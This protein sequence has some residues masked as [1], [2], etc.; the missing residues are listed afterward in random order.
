MADRRHSF[1]A[2]L[3]NRVKKRAMSCSSP[4]NLVWASHW[5]LWYHQHLYI[6]VWRFRV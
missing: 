2:F 4:R 6:S 1:P 3:K 5:N